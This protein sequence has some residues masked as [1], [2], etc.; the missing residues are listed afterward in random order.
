MGEILL[1]IIMLCQTPEAVCQFSKIDREILEV[2]TPERTICFRAYTKQS[3]THHNN[4]ET[5]K[6]TQC[7]D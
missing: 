7:L 1:L 2:K 5:V 4:V 3:G 6:R